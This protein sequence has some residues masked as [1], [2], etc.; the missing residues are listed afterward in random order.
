MI[1]KPGK[2]KIEARCALAADVD[3][4]LANGGEIEK[5]DSFGMRPKISDVSAVR[6]SLNTEGK[7]NKKS[8]GVDASIREDLLAGMGVSGVARKHRVSTSTVTRRKDSLIARGELKLR[9]V[10]I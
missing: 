7:V 10:Q 9:E 3:A 5:L 2:V 4:F 8:E 6:F 1:N